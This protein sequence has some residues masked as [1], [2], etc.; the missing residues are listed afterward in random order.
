MGKSGR[1]KSTL[2]RLIMPLY[3]PIGGRVLLDG[4]DLRELR[5]SY[6]RV[7]LVFDNH[8]HHLVLHLGRW[9]SYISSIESVVIVPVLSKQHIYRSFQHWES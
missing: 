6:H 9:E 2:A 7:F 3:E 4:V 1:T 8:H 5:Q